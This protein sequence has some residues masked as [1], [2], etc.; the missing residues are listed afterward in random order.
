MAGREVVRGPHVEDDAG[1]R[2][3]H[4]GE[5][6]LGR[7]ERPAIEL[8]DVLHVRRPGGLWAA[9]LR[10]ELVVRLGERV[11]VAALEADRRRR[12]RAHGSAAKRSGDV[13][14]VD[15]DPVAEIDEPVQRVE[16]PLG[17]V[18]RLDREVGPRGVADEER[19]AREHEPGLVTA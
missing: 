6:R 5:R 16:E 3:V 19:V 12:L 18:L 7:Q 14:W 1:I 8:D 10:E 17:A 13:P 15:L 2:V 9:G 4:A 11:V